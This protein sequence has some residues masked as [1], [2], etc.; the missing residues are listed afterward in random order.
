M[1]GENSRDWGILRGC[2]EDDVLSTRSCLLCPKVPG[3]S[4]WWWNERHTLL[5][6]ASYLKGANIQKQTQQLLQCLLGIW[7]QPKVQNAEHTSHFWSQFH[8]F[9][10]CFSLFLSNKHGVNVSSSQLSRAGWPVLTVTQELFSF[11]LK[12]IFSGLPDNEQQPANFSVS[13]NKGLGVGE[14]DPNLV[15]VLVFL[16]M[17]CDIDT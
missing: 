7:V 13:W 8:H 10:T 5:S 15:G 14:I 16:M 1:P 3:L 11:P 6:Q 2:K 4:C 12:S 17:T 9:I